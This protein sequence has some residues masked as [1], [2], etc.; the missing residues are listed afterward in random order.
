MERSEWEALLTKL[1]ESEFH[2]YGN[3]IR[4]ILRMRATESR[5]MIAWTPDAYDRI[6]NILIVLEQEEKGADQFRYSC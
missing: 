1:D 5:V 3:L 2:I 6:T 4:I